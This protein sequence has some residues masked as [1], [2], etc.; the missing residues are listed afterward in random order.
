MHRRKEIQKLKL[1]FTFWLQ[2]NPPNF[3]PF[4]AQ[5]EKIE[6]ITISD[7]SKSLVAAVVDISIS[8]VESG[9]TSVGAKVEFGDVE[10]VD[11]VILK[12]AVNTHNLGII[13]AKK[14]SIIFLFSSV[15]NFHLFFY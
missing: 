10:L 6:M 15:I 12:I 14:K 7:V 1:S 8:P 11:E 4:E 5:P 2:E 13:L 3:A 9:K